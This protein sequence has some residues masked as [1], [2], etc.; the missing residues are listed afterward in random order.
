[1]WYPHTPYF[2]FG[3]E[4]TAIILCL[5]ALDA[6]CNFQQKL[7]ENSITYRNFS[8]KVAAERFDGKTDI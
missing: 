5:D 6:A 8:A 7:S 2:P 3:G 4:F 1:M